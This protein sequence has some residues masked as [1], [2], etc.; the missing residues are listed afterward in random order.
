MAAGPARFSVTPQ[1][2]ESKNRSD[3]FR[4]RILE[5]SVDFGSTKIFRVVG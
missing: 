2:T 5:H 3:D 1:E 4:L